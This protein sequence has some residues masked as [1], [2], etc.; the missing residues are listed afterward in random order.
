MQRVRD[1]GTLNPKRDFYIKFL[2]PRLSERQKKRKS[3]IM[4]G[5]GGQTIKALKSHMG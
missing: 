5:D 4:R 3:E 2:L 1:S